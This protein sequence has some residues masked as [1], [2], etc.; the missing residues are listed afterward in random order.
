MQGF[1]YRRQQIGQLE[2]LAALIPY[3]SLAPRLA[4]KRV[5]HWIDNSSA[6][7]AL[8]K[9]YSSAPDSARLVHAFHATAAGLGC[10]C[11][12]EYVKS[13]ANPADVPSREDLSDTE[14]DCGL[15]GRGV[16]SRPVPA[17]L[18]PD[19]R[20]ADAAAQWTLR[21]AKAAREL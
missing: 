5:I 1:V 3:L 6:V 16:K 2:I 12:F 15:P 13:S 7:A 9:G 4:G 18:P 17:C 8:S 20:W 11:W 19:T 10:A 21:A 14:W